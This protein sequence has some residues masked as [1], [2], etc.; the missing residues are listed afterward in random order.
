VPL[1]VAAPNLPAGRV[2]D[3]MVRLID[4]APTLLDRAVN[5]QPAPYEISAELSGFANARR[6]FTLIVGTDATVDLRLGVAALTENITV[7]GESPL[8]EVTKSQPSSSSSASG[9][10]RCRCS[11]A[12][13]WC[14][15][16]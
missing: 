12:T 6:S 10:R 16:S 11:I 3:S 4:V 13:S 8:V 1:I 2:V 9:W 15:R 7:R 5:L 14:W